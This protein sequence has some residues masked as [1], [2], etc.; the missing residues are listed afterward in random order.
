M[1]AVL[2]HALQSFLRF[3]SLSIFNHFAGWHSSGESIKALLQTG[4]CFTTTISAIL[5]L[6]ASSP[7]GDC[8]KKS[9]A[10]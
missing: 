9:L 2:I 3:A 6:S 5:R 1:E 7:S 4:E 10:F 8:K